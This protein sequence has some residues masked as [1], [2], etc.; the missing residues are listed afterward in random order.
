MTS[1]AVPSAVLVDGGH[2]L[3][4]GGHWFDDQ[5]VYV[6][7]LSGRLFE[8]RDDTGPTAP[9]QPAALDVPLGAVV[10]VGDTPGAWIAAAGT[11]IALLT[12]DGALEWLD[13]SEDRTPSPAG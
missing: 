2:E 8:L 6:D 11:G 10:L 4:E 3:A 9:R 1:M 13:F 7:I 5:Y 12:A